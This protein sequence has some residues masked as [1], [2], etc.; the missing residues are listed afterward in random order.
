MFRLK[1]ERTKVHWLL[2]ENTIMNLNHKTQITTAANYTDFYLF[3]YFYFAEKIRP[4]ISCESSE[5]SS[6]IFSE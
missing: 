6:S 1:N 4:D 5:M 2:K 3:I